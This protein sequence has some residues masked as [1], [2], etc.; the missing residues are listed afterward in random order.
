MVGTAHFEV[1]AYVSRGANPDHTTRISG[2]HT[3]VASTGASNKPVDTK[4][5]R[6]YALQAILGISRVLG[7]KNSYITE[8]S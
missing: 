5:A 2:P 1:T 7:K 6:R 8:A 3:E 4:K